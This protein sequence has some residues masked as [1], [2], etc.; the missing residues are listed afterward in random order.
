[1]ILKIVE[2]NKYLAL[3]ASLC[4]LFVNTTLGIDLRTLFLYLTMYY[5]GLITLR[6]LS[7]S[8]DNVLLINGIHNIWQRQTR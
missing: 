2:L 6:E 3:L 7:V 4:P 5:Y 1:M 8:D